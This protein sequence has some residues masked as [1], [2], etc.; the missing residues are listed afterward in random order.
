MPSSRRLPVDD[1]PFSAA[2]DMCSIAMNDDLKAA[3]IEQ[4]RKMEIPLVGVAN[5][6]RWE[7]PPFLP[8]MPE[9]FYPQSIFPGA[10]S[11]IVIAQPILNAVMDA[12]AVLMDHEI[13]LVPP[14]GD[15]VA[16]RV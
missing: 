2:G 14:P 11:V 9:D 8:W 4:C 3:V 6:E 16:E 7:N 10:R 15:L 5:T 1:E 13:D 12:P